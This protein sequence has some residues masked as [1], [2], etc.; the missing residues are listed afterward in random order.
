MIYVA[1]IIMFT[2]S[3]LREGQLTVAP[4]TY[5]HHYNTYLAI[6]CCINVFSNL[7]YRNRDYRSD[8]EESVVT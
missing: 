7:I 8:L 1:Q 2:L 5:V 4:Y 6:M 3:E